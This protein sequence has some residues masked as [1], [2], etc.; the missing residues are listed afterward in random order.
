MEHN[1]LIIGNWKLQ[2]A[3]EKEALA[4]AN[5]LN[6]EIRPHKKITSAY[7]VPAAFLLSLKKKFPK[8]SFGAQDVSAHE[9]GAHTGEHT[10]KMLASVGAQFA[11]IGHSE[12]RARGVSNDMTRDAVRLALKEKMMVV[13]CVGERER[14]ASHAYLRFVA[15]QIKDA[16]SAVPKSKIADI[17]LAYE[18]VWAIGSDAARV[19][20]PEECLEMVIFI[21]RTLADMFGKKIAE[22]VRVLYGGSVDEKNGITFLQ[23][24]GVN[25][26]LAGRVSLSP[27]KFSALI[28][29]ITL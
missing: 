11:L 1:T 29:S 24:G 7:A 12:T 22:S 9:N 14:D 6:K 16:L 21:R 26:L 19:A 10:A 23:T 27:K 28:R 5:A 18:P 2:P 4:L 20:T 17:V 15:D 25:G 8:L 13:L 3:T